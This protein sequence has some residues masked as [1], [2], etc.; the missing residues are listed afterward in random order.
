MKLPPHLAFILALLHSALCLRWGP[1]YEKAYR[2]GAH[3]SPARARDC[4]QARNSGSWDL[5]EHEPDDLEDH[6]DFSV[7]GSAANFQRERYSQDQSPSETDDSVIDRRSGF[8]AS[9]HSDEP[10]DSEQSA[11]EPGE[12]HS[13]WDQACDPRKRPVDDADAHNYNEADPDERSRLLPQV[14]RG[15]QFTVVAPRSY[16]SGLQE[17]RQVFSSLNDQGF[18]R[19]M[20]DLSLEDAPE[21]RGRQSLGPLSRRRRSR[22]RTRSRSRSKSRD[23]RKFYPGSGFGASSGPRKARPL[24]RR[25]S[26]PQ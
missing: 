6:V 8:T 19:E 17:N 24:S 4:Q 26:R 22:S 12:S 3:S 2:E 15:T 21:S 16:G 7:F 14:K 10:S 25:S 9:S 11:T 23:S 5:P 13:S 1:N 18:L 20:E